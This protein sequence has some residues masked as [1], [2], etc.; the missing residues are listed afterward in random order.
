MSQYSF[1]CSYFYMVKKLIP[2]PKSNGDLFMENGKME[3]KE[4]LG[5]N[6]KN[7]LT[8][9]WKK[10]ALEVQ[11]WKLQQEFW[12]LLEHHWEQQRHLQAPPN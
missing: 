11:D 9:C 2:R 1:L 3:T 5:Q 10:G 4:S 8:D 12:E 7:Y 6:V